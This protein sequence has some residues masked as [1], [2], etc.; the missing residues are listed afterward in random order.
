MTDARHA[1]SVQLHEIDVGLMQMFGLVIEGISK[2]TEVVLDLDMAGAQAIIDGD[3]ELDLIN[4]DVE[5]LCAQT[6]ALQQPVA[7]DLRLLI[8]GLK[9]TGELE[10]SGDLVT[11]IAKGT[12][13]IASVDLQP[14]LRGLIE[15]MRQQAVLLFQ[16]AS[17]AYSGRDATL[18]A[19]LP[20]LD[21][22]LDRLHAEFVE[23]VV[24]SHD[25]NH[26]DVQESV[27]LCLLARF[28]ERIGDHA[29]NVGER[30]QYMVT[31]WLPEHDGAERARSRR[32]DPS[33][34]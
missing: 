14:H 16:K 19:A 6:L 13:R 11:N 5:E 20:G 7:S 30:I 12:Q 24:N 33:A 31:G 10:R 23:A 4:T 28:Y 2:V 29:V 27:Q 22:Q 9:I 26:L 17:D 8:S 25:E 18:A 3:D 1:F 21:D 15:Q 34:D 32:E